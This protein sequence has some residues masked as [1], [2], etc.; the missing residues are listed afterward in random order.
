M[1]HTYN[2]T[3]FNEARK[4]KHDI[5]GD[6]TDKKKNYAPK[7]QRAEP[8]C[9]F[10]PFEGAAREQ[11][12]HPA[13]V[14]KARLFSFFSCSILFSIYKLTKM[15]ACFG[16]HNLPWSHIQTCRSSLSLRPLR[17]VESVHGEAA[18]H[19]D[20]L[21]RHE[22]RAGHGQKGAQAAHFLGGAHPVEV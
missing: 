2:A 6:K 9:K 15:V 1:P 16:Y 3:N 22:R 14:L 4:T 11:S 20:G 19:T 21:S 17:L 13:F 10:F 8:A 5:R 18:V 12:A 7:S